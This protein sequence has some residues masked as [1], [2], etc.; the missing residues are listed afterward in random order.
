MRTIG[1]IFRHELRLLAA[2]RTLWVVSFL[3]AL[4][5]L[6]ALVNGL[7]DTRERESVIANVA[8]QQAKRV[9]AVLEQLARVTSGLE[10]PDPF[11]NPVDPASAGSGDVGRHAILPYA[12]LAPI[13]FGQSDL[14]PNYYRMSYRAKSNFMDDGELENPW[15]L[16]TGRFDFAFV[17]VVLLPLAILALTYNMLSGE[18]EQGTLKLVLAQGGRP[19]SLILGKLFARTFPVLSVTLGVLFIFVL[20]TR[21][22]DANVAIQLIA[23]ACVI[24]LYSAFWFAIATLMNVLNRSSAFNAIVLVGAWVGLVL[25]VPIVMNLA[26]QSAHP[27]PSRTQFATQ[28]RLITIEGLNRYNDLLSAD[29]RYVSEPEVLKPRADGTFDVQPRR[30]AHFLLARDVDQ[31]LDAEREKF[32]RQLKVQQQSVDT[33]GFLSPAIVAYESLTTFAGTDS[34]RYLRFQSQVDAF[35]REWKAFF[36]PRVLGGRA[37]TAE[38]YAK[39]PAFAWNETK[40][41]EHW[42]LLFM[43]TLSLLIPVCLLAFFAWRRLSGVRAA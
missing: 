40:D 32:D 33:F 5:S 23:L 36:E 28:N 42:Q 21:A 25:V 17:V 10:S 4:V 2:E 15:N 12:A 7:A 31:L 27:L 3:I 9:P 34:A 1:L 26:I 39:L 38:D 8:E 30:R 41:A 43:R 37:M 14:M 13:A 19:G 24:A 18:R 20:A 11:A 16:L 22:V 6:Y 35:H 29:Y